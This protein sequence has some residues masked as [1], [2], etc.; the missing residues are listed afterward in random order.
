M[1]FL[2]FINCRM[3]DSF[4]NKIYNPGCSPKKISK[5]KNSLKIDIGKNMQQTSGFSHSNNRDSAVLSGR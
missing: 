4:M 5:Q 2:S 1:S 3:I